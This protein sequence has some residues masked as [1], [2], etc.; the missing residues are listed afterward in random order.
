MWDSDE[1]KYKSLIIVKRD[2]QHLHMSNL[3][4]LFRLPYSRDDYDLF[5]HEIQEKNMLES[6][7]ELK[8]IEQENS[9][10]NY[11]KNV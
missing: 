3:Q 6:K 11:Y 8:I 9:S 5:N 10:R 4:S 1:V 7:C 2:V